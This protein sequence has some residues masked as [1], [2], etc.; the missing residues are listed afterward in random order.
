MYLDAEHNLELH[1]SLACTVNDRKTSLSD[2]TLG[3]L[4]TLL[5]ASMCGIKNIRFNKQ[6]AGT[7]HYL[8]V[9][10]KN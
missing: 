4:E 3:R 9:A 6:D 8:V 10:I 5:A 1:G 7:D 2:A